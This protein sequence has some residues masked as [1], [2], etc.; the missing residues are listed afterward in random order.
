MLASMASTSRAGSHTT[1][2]AATRADLELRQQAEELEN[3]LLAE[4]AAAELYHQSTAAA[5]QEP[6][7]RS[8][9][10]PPSRK[11]AAAAKPEDVYY[12]SSITFFSSPSF[13]LRGFKKY[14][15]TAKCTLTRSAPSVWLL[16][17]EPGFLT[18][19][20]HFI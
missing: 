13:F 10:L 8:R 6:V 19:S 20:R 12:D 9:T 1:T 15:S 3:K 18:V 16:F 11:P 4:L 17:R 14:R 2:L 5:A 7:P